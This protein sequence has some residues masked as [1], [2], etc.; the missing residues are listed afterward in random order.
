MYCDGSPYLACGYSKVRGSGGMKPCVLTLF[1][2]I[3]YVSIIQ[4]SLS[5]T[6]EVKHSSDF[7]SACFLP[8]F[9]MTNLIPQHVPG[10]NDSFC[11]N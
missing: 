4:K 5:L 2:T 8:L 6:A 1:L 11:D 3:F 7:K 10:L 9:C